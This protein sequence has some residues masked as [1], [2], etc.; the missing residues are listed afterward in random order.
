MVKNNQIKKITI[1]S[2]IS[3]GQK[4]YH[5]HVTSKEDRRFYLPIADADT[6]V[7]NLDNSIE[8]YIAQGSPYSHGQKIDI[9]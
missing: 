3:E 1:R 5:A 2:L 4:H 9:E 6:F 8:L 7:L